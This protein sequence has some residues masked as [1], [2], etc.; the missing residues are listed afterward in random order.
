M[1][2]MISSS[3]TAGSRASNL[4]LRS[5]ILVSKKSIFD[6]IHQG[7]QRRRGKNAGRFPENRAEDNTGDGRQNHIAPVGHGLRAVVQVRATENQ[8]C[9]QQREVARAEALKQPVL[10]ETA[11]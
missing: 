10:H 9:R 2:S 11:E 5:G 4:G 3:S 6:R 1:Y 8:A 7:V